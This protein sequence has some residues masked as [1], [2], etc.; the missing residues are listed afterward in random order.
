MEI[1][2]NCTVEANKEYRYGNIVFHRKNI[3]KNHCSLYCLIYRL[4]DLSKFVT[5]S[6]LFIPKS[7]GIIPYPYWKMCFGWEQQIYESYETLLRWRQSMTLEVRP[8]FKPQIRHQNEIWKTIFFGD[9]RNTKILKVNK[10]VMKNLCQ[11]SVDLSWL[12][13][14]MINYD[15]TSI[16]GL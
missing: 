6:G 1:L 7:Q 8:R 5:V 3:F 15:M 16:E 4:T 2:S 11:K 9:F 14:C 13:S 10:I 12:H